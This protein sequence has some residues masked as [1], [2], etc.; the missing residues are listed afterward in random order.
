[1][2]DAHGVFL[3]AD[4]I[5]TG[6]G[7]TGT[8]FACEQAGVQPDLMCVSKG[9]TGGFLPLAAVLATQ[10]IYNGFLADTRERAFLHSHSYTGNPLACA[11]ALA[12]LRIFDTDD[13]LARNRATA[14][15]MAELA[16][17][18]ASHRH[19]ADV[20]QAG[21][22]VAFEL[23]RDGDRRTPF[24]PASRVGLRAYRAALE[25]GVVLRPLGDIL[26]W[27]PPYCIDEA[28]LSLLAATT[29]AVIDEATACA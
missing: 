26:Y 8:L 11:A 24:D 19:V 2:C 27:M 16:R 28:Q 7:R 12:S 10:A 6:F 20:R 21:M 14:A 25:R 17:P 13:V 5:A 22:V 3:V 23:T 18:L 4:E 9:L 29:Q 15:R 1:L